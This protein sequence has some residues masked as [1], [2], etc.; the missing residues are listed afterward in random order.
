MRCYYCNHTIRKVTI[1]CPVCNRQQNLSL[2]ERLSE[3]LKNLLLKRSLR[4]RP[5]A[6]Y[7]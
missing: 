2:V 1:I 5:F 7:R 3:Y 4:N 6:F